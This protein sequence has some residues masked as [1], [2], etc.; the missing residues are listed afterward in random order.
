MD[1]RYRVVPSLCCLPFINTYSDFDHPEVYILILPG[2]GI[3]SHHVLIT[4]EIKAIQIYR[5]S[6]SYNIHWLSYI[7]SIGFLGFTAWAH[8]IFMVSLDVD[9]R[10]S[11]TSA[12]AIITIPAGIKVFV[13]PV[14]LHGRNIKRSPAGSTA[15]GF[16]STY[17]RWP[18][19]NCFYQ[20]PCYY[21]RVCPLVSTIP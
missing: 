11:F 18:K 16:I 10:A 8:H 21:S 4:L 3:I 17:S 20:T 1:V 6:M 9:T 7:L 14:A 19:R 5:N 2:F 12:T 15:L 13:R